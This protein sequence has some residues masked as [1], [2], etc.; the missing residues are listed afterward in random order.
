MVICNSALR[1]LGWE[2]TPGQRATLFSLLF[3]LGFHGFILKQVLN[4]LIMTLLV[5]EAGNSIFLDHYQTNAD[6]KKVK[7]SVCLIS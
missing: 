4:H 3:H 1:A 6:Y 2:K 5:V 7:L